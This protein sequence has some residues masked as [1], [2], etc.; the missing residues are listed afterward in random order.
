VRNVVKVECIL[1]VTKRHHYIGVKNSNGSSETRTHLRRSLVMMWTV[2]MESGF[3]PLYLALFVVG[4]GLT[5]LVL[6]GF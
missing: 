4:S 1:R 2:G 3:T 5:G 6:L